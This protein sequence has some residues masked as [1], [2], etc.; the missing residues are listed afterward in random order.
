[1]RARFYRL[2][3]YCLSIV[4]YISAVL[5]T[6][7]AFPQ[8][9]LN[10]NARPLNAISLTYNT[11]EG[12]EIETGEVSWYSFT[13]GS[14]YSNSWGVVQLIG[15][16]DTTSLKFTVYDSND[17]A[18]FGNYTHNGSHMCESAYRIEG[19]DT[20]DEFMP[21][22]N[23]G[24]TY[25]IAV[26][27]TGEYTV[28]VYTETD[29]YEGDYTKAAAT[30][31]A[32]PYTGKI[33]RSDDIDC[34]SITFPNDSNS[35][36]VSLYATK[37]MTARICDSNNNI[38]AN[39]GLNVMRDRQTSEVVFKG[40]GQ[41][42]YF[43]LEGNGGTVYRFKWDIKNTVTNITGSRVVAQIG[44]NSIYIYTVKRSKVTVLSNKKII[45]NKKKKK[46]YKSVS[47]STIV[48]PLNR[49]LRRGD[50]IRVIIE[51]GRLKKYTKKIKIK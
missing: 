22:L 36:Q 47:N 34:F 32:N 42:L 43:Y 30:T 24:W 37:K 29:D 28:A 48:V 13:I 31:I 51:K 14:T 41:T 3:A 18:V 11:P 50:V 16:E 49:N 33:E 2:S 17:N 19:T 15:Y 38:I 8:G 45:R 4:I 46:V 9:T 25:Y 27:G 12:G 20:N 44:Q 21:R 5:V 1:M 10:V 39:T 26:E 7:F 35:Y 40:K 6:F 23:L